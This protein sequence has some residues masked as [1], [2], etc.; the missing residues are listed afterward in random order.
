MIQALNFVVHQSRETTTQA[1]YEEL[2]QMSQHVLD[3]SRSNA[4]M[5]DRTL[6]ALQCLI[7]IYF[8]MSQKVDYELGI[9]DIRSTIHLKGIDLAEHSL[10][11]KT[12]IR[13]FSEPHL[14]EGMVSHFFSCLNRLTLFFFHQTV[15]VHSYSSVVLD[16]IRGVIERGNRIKV[17]TTEGMPSHTG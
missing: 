2:K 1:M 15:L 12:L 11:F 8:R 10:H 13:K 6:L 7:K 4:G 9:E 3:F 16:V 5:G 14:R 17:I